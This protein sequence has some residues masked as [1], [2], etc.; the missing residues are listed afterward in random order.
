MPT[1]STKI[2]DYAAARC[3]ELTT[4]F[5]DRLPEEPLP[6]STPGTERRRQ[7]ALLA[8]AQAAC[9]DYPLIIDFST[10]RSW[11]TT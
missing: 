4:V 1:S 9:Q 3:L 5:Q 2:S 7:L 6:A 10:G 11:S 8:T